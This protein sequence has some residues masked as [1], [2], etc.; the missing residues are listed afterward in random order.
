M[1]KK[2][3]STVSLALIAF[4]M[5]AMVAC[6]SGENPVSKAPASEPPED[7]GT[8]ATSDASGTENEETEGWV[9]TGT[10]E[11]IVPY[12]AGGSSDL[13]A[14]AVE[15]V[16]S[17]YCDQ[18]VI[19][20]NMPGGGGV[21]GSMHV[22]AAKPDGQTL[23]IGYGSG[24]DMSM[25]F[26][27]EMDYDPF[28][29]LDPI[30]RLSVHNVM[31]ATLPDSEFDTL[32]DIVKWSGETG[33]SIT[34]SSST[35]NGTVDL[36]FK[37]F[38]YATETN[39]NIVPHDGTADSITDLLSGSYMIGGGHPSDVLPY[40]Q[41]GQ[42]KLLGVAADERDSAMPDVPTLIEQDIDFWAYGSIKGIACPENTPDEIKAY[43]EKLFERICDDEEFV[44][45][46]TG[47][48]QPV[49]YQN[50]EDFTKYF[51]DASAAYQK[52][53]EDLGIAYYS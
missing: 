18:S 29:L 24:C 52:V 2:W 21:S 49:M 10:V 25:P 6:S 30:C 45:I 20:T 53:I 23:L 31:M 41:S 33:E 46:M 16:W 28:E 38:A 3:K 8:P 17:K 50:T 34:A 47:M 40:V 44:T 26:L 13:L 42:L 36:V 15:K 12:S 51:S 19:V 22:A 32:A 1:M 48:A 14:R 35:A 39:M 43:Y 11:L 27:Q 37:A 4:M 7:S 5:L 9:P